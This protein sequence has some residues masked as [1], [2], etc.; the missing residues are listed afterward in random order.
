MTA[1]TAVRPSIV[2]PTLIVSEPT[3]SHS[4]ISKPKSCPGALMTSISAHT[5][6][7]KAAAIA[8]TVRY[9]APRHRD[10]M[11][12]RSRAIRTNDPRGRKKMDQT[13][14]SGT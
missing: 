10:P 9:P 3:V 13:S 1:I 8:A 5:E 12:G 7:T 2:M 4:R 11:T 14:I 6:R